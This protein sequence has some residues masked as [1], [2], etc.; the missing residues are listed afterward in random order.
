MNA[1]ASPRVGLFA[2]CL[3]NL[4]RPNIGFS[5]VELLERAGCKVEVPLEQTCCGQPAYSSGED[6]VARALARQTIEQFEAFDYVVAP[7]GSCV[8]TLRKYTDLLAADPQWAGRAKAFAAKSHELLSFLCMRGLA[9]DAA[10]AGV[11][12]YH[13]SCSGL[14]ELGIKAEPRQL[15]AGV[16]GLQLKEMDDAEVCC[17]FGGSFCLKYPAISEK[18]TD[19]KLASVAASGADTLLGGDLGCLL[20]I[21]GRLKRMG[22][23]VRVWHAAEVLAGRTEGPAI[24]EGEKP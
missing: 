4:F 5:A 24:G 1:P 18:I 23:P 7:S 8:G 11:V 13:D 15:L 10:Y 20:S 21:A 16:S 2:T 19:D 14:R 9:V 6:D 17:G 3:M 12:T 22:S